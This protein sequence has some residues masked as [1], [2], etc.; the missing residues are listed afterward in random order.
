MARVVVEVGDRDADEREP[1]RLDLGRRRRAARAAVEDRLGGRAGGG[2]CAT[3]RARE[4]VEA[5][6]QHDRAADAARGPHPPG[7]PVDE[8]DDDRVDR[9]GDHGA[10]RAPA[11]S[12]SNRGGGRPAPAADRGCAPAS[13]GG[14]PTR[15]RVRDQPASA[16]SATSP[17]V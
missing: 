3:R 1:A 15:G 12:R 13:A 10:G 9:W 17:T 2:G 5:Q 11:A 6:A 8:P 16:S 7:D 14:G 4:V